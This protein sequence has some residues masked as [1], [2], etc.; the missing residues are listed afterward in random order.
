MQES[1]ISQGLDLMLF[2]LGTVFVFLAV[3]VVVTSLMSVVVVR[4]FPE[5]VEPERLRN[6]SPAQ[7]AVDSRVLKILQAAVDQHR[8]KRRR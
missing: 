8:A 5:P 6:P 1:L 3:L 4:L 7:P 2:G